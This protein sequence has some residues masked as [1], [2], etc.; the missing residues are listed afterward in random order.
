MVRDGAGSARRLRKTNE[1]QY[2][3]SFDPNYFPPTILLT[4]HR[5]RNAPRAIL[6]DPRWSVLGYP[7]RSIAKPVYAWNEVTIHLRRSTR[8]TIPT[9]LVSKRNEGGEELTIC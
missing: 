6:S 9:G 8:G 3:I 1:V 7:H 2:A 4:H 5:S